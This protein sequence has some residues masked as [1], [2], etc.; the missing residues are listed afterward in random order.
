MLCFHDI[1]QRVYDSPVLQLW[2]RGKCTL[3]PTSAS[4]LLQCTHHTKPINAAVPSGVHVWRAVH[5]DRVHS[6]PTFLIF[7]QHWC[8]ID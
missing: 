6:V 2:G 1:R 7:N 4:A 5:M 8:N 3:L